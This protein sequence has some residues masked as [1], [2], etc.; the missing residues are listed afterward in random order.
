MKA[1]YARGE[2]IA[3][4]YPTAL[5][6]HYANLPHLPHQP[7]TQPSPRILRP[8]DRPHL[9]RPLRRPTPLQTLLVP[10]CAVTRGCRDATT[11]SNGRWPTGRSRTSSRRCGSRTAAGTWARGPTTCRTGR[12]RMVMPSGRVFEGE[13]R[14]GTF[15]GDVGRPGWAAVRGGVGVNDNLWW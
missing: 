6:P 12:G 1:A 8:H 15:V 9:S 7:P 5:P 3:P 11:R 10:P 2:V 13:F 4:P 14:R